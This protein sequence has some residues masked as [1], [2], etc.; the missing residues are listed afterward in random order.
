MEDGLHGIQMKA[1]FESE[2]MPS[3]STLSLETCNEIYGQLFSLEDALVI[4]LL[5][6]RACTGAGMGT[7]ATALQ[8]S[9]Y[10]SSCHYLLD[11]P[12]HRMT[13][14]LKFV[15]PSGWPREE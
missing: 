10:H 14:S 12:I 6:Q 3:S 8:V 5:Q 1:L 13:V 9:Y 2:I 11:D 7:F 4:R 15:S